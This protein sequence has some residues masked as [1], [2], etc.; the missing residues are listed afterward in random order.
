MKEFLIDW[1]WLLIIPIAAAVIVP[2]GIW[3][4]KQQAERYGVMEARIMNIEIVLDYDLPDDTPLLERITYAE[5]VLGILPPRG[6]WY[7]QEEGLK[8]RLV[9]LKGRM[10]DH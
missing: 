1:S 4:S 2:L 7:R 8:H 3:V 9:Y 6:R 10:H 5:G